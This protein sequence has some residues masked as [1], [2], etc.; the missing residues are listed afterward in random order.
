[1]VLSDVLC[2]AICVCC[3]T[4]LLSDAMRITSVKTTSTVWVHLYV[5]LVKTTA[6][7]STVSCHLFVLLMLR[8]PELHC[9]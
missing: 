6:E 4:R 9:I 5:L 3:L 2:D 8:L 7:A 1:M